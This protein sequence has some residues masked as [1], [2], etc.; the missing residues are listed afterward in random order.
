MANSLNKINSGGI[1]DDSIVNADIK[2]DAAIALSKLASTPA[3]LTGS[4]DNTIT[5]VT[6]ANAIQGESNLTFDGSTLDCTGKI[7]VDISSTGT[8]GSGAAE[9]IFLRNTN[10]TDNNAVTIFGG[11]DDYGA[12][13]SAIN[14]VNVDHSANAGSISFD[15]R[16]T[17]N[18]Y[19][20]RLRIDSS[21]NVGIGT[22]SPANPLEVKTTGTST[23]VFGN[24]TAH[25]RSDASGRDAHIA[26][27]DNVNASAAIG[28][29]NPDLYFYVAGAERARFASGNFNITGN[30]VMAAAGK[31]IDFSD[32]GDAAGATAELLDDYEIGTFTPILGGSNYGSYY[33]SG[34]GKYTKIGRQ[35]FFQLA[36]HNK[37]LDNN[38]AGNMRIR[39]FPYSWNTTSGRP[40]IPVTMM[41]NI[42]MPDSNNTNPN[43]YTVYGDSDGITLHGL[44][45]HDGVAWD[46]WSITSFEAAGLYL[47]ITG[48]Y[49]TS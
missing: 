34:T 15:T 4:T 19:A 41:Y 16:T 40:A 47:D 27:G 21:G 38:A 9:G 25:F 23:S 31:G 26:F 30:L 7:R 48:S 1:K 5:T 49:M 46:G 35:V 20:E 44:S 22:A 13:A 32:T 17:G 28:Y 43:T 2:S 6:G 12:A 29:S 33:I 24:R 18:S 37:D 8:V 14:F 11:A 42:T 10:E 39:S 36:F 3:V 45:S